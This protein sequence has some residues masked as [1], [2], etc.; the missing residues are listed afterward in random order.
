MLDLIAHV[1][2]PPPALTATVHYWLDTLAARRCMPAL[3]AGSAQDDMLSSTGFIGLDDFT[4]LPVLN[5]HRVA[6]LTAEL[7]DRY[8]IEFL[9]DKRPRRPQILASDGVRLRKIYHNRVV[10]SPP[11]PLPSSYVRLVDPAWLLG[12][13]RLSEDGEHAVAG[14]TAIRLVAELPQPPAL[15]ESRWSADSGQIVSM[16]LMIDTTL[17]VILRQVSFCGDQPVARFE[18]REVTTQEAS[19]LAEFG[20]G[21]APDLPVHDTDSGPAGDLDLPDAARTVSGVLNRL[22]RRG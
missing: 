4:A 20:A 19:D 21:I 10:A 22:I 17:G 1:G 16:E 12:D 6:R 8:R 3:A 11:L 7:P 5:V 15:S 18:L 9:R 14:R 13:W 2:L